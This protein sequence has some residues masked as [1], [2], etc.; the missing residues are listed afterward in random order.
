[1]LA[2]PKQV[3][4]VLRKRNKERKGESEHWP[5]AQAINWSD[6]GI[7]QIP[8]CLALAGR[9]WLAAEFVL[10]ITRRTE[11]GEG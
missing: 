11:E 10:V 5:G 9:P 6:D 1:M 8:W 7:I 4:Y 3:Q 2:A